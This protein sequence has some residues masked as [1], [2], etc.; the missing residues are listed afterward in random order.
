M[1]ITKKVIGRLGGATDTRELGKAMRLEI[2]F[3]ASFNDGRR[4]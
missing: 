1:R 2:E 3:P 4:N